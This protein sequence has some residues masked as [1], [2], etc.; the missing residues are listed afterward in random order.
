MIFFGPGTDCIHKTKDWFGSY[1]H[2]SVV[3]G[4]K[5]DKT[6]YHTVEQEAGR[7]VLKLLDAKIGRYKFIW[8]KLYACMRYQTARACRSGDQGR[9]KIVW[10]LEQ[11]INNL[12]FSWDYNCSC[13]LKAELLFLPHSPRTILITTAWLYKHLDCLMK[14]TQNI[15]LST[16]IESRCWHC[17]PHLHPIQHCFDI[18]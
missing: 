18:S 8:I 7:A 14:Q 3:P 10:S 15:L 11:Q 12:W 4:S 2:F 6:D 16:F 17:L 13:W 5:R 9:L 1:S